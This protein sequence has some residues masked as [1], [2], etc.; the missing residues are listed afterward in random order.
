MLG[1]PKTIAPFFRIPG[2][3]RQEPV[4]EYLQAHHYATWSLDFLADD[5]THISAKEITRRALQRIEARGRGILLLHDIQPAT[6]LALPTILAELKARG[7]KIVHVVPATPDRPATVAEND[8]WVQ[9]H[10]THGRHGRGSW[11]WA[12][13]RRNPA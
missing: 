13:R 5:W 6:A 2:L 1:D 8:D 10:H 12:P 11:R 9:R 4:E 7:Y 3:L